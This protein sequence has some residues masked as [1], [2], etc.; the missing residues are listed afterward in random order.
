M[1]DQ[2][3]AISAAMVK[4]LRERTSAGMM[5]CKKYL[6]KAEADIEL[7]IELMRKDGTLK[8]A[9]KEGRTT[10]EGLVV[11]ASHG[12]F[13]VM[14]EVNCETDFVARGDDF[15]DFAHRCAEVALENHSTAV[16]DLMETTVDG[17]TI[18]TARAELVAK[19][20]E[21]INVRRLVSLKPQ[22]MIG[23]Y[24]HGAK[25]G[26]MVD[27]SGG[28][29]ELAKDI[30]MHI[31]AQAPVVVSPDQVS[32][33][34]IAKEREIYTAQAKESGKPAEIVEKMV[35]GRI[36]KFLDEVSLLGQPFV[37]NPD[38]KIQQLL[39]NANATINQFFRFSVGE[40]IEKQESNFV[41]EVMAQARGE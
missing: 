15:K 41:E 6:Q 11:V 17:K 32:E 7:A 37:K 39:S 1:S 25:I 14:L 10:A 21:N 18:E 34:L 23:H 31:A 40:G 36:N 12:N 4:E 27:I 35:S 9:K 38:I 29:S 28:D 30:A 13:G 2:T 20:G 24:S 22:G 5:E 8:A 3:K 16:E 26:V 33:E 19:I